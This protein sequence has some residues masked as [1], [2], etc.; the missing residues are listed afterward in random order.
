MAGLGLRAWLEAVG[1]SSAVLYYIIASSH[2][3]VYDWIEGIMTRMH[4]WTKGGRYDV[5]ILGSLLSENNRGRARFFVLDR[6]GS[7]A[8]IPSHLARPRQNA[9]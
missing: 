8:H 6:I 5:V 4:F 1:Y 3:E 9:F 7:Y 2:F